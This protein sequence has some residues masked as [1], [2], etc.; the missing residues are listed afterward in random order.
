MK[1]MALL[2]PRMVELC[3]GPNLS[4][5]GIDAGVG[6]NIWHIVEGSRNVFERP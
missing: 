4:V 5:D 3:A 6:L 2:P 1:P